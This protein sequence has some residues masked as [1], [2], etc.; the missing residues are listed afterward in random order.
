MS[1][2]QG[3][4]CVILAGGESKRMGADKAHVQ[5]AGRTLIERVLATVMP[6]FDDVMISGRD[7]TSEINGTR[8]VKD[9]HAGRGPAIGLCTAMQEARHPHLFA[10]ACDMPFVT[11]GLIEHL[12]S[13]PDEYDV[14]VPM[15]GGRLEPL[16]A[17]YRTACVR[18]LEQ[19]IKK[20]ERGLSS[21][22]ENTP[23]L[24]VRRISEQEL[25]KIDPALRSFLDIDSA[26]ALAQAERMLE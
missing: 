11:P 1:P 13:S 22:I 14:V 5:L 3:V 21:F 25:R 23:E 2:I 4:S 6:L 16:C 19:C 9:R 20:G 10:I 7:N 24:K 18:E 12:A 15:R 8:F 26:D 17:L